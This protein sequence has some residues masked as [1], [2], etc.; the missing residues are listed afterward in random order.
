V[1][2][3]VL[4]QADGR[5][6]GGLGGRQGHAGWN[7]GARAVASGRPQYARKMPAA[8]DRQQRCSA[9]QNRVLLRNVGNRGSADLRAGVP[10]RSGTPLG[11]PVVDEM[12]AHGA[13]VGATYPLCRELPRR[14]TTGRV[15]IAGVLRWICC[16]SDL[17]D[18]EW[19]RLAP[20]SSCRW[21]PRTAADPD[22]L[23]RAR[24][25][26]RRRLVSAARYPAP[27]RGLT[28]PAVRPAAR[29]SSFATASL[30]P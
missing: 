6:G 4:G 3:R 18:A 21:R 28:R 19:A 27:P 22:V 2:G 29:P 5:R 11:V 8:A 10:T 9:A 30:R 20:L 7:A 23:R 25:T 12:A 13:V 24:A 17:A 14:G 26:R 1:L 16:S 15:A